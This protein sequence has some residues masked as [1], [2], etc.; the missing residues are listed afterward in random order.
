MTSTAVSTPENTRPARGQAAREATERTFRPEIQGLRA[1]AVLMVVTY[2][3]WFGRVSGGV[4]AFL[5]I[6]AFLMT[7][8]FTRR[9]E[10]GR[11]V[12]LP[13]HYLHVFRR[14]LPAAVLVI[15]SVLIAVRFLIPATRW[16][17]IIGQGLAS[18]FYAQNWALQA[19][20]VDYYASDHSLASPFQHFWSLSIQGQVFILWPLIFVLCA[21]LAR[22]TGW[23]H[24]WILTAVFSAI[25]LASFLHSVEYTA[26][27]Q[28]L[29]YFDTFSRLWEFALGSLLALLLPYLQPSK[30]LRVILG[31]AGVAAMLS[32]G[33][34]LD[35]QGLFPGYVA[36]W[37][38]LAVS[39]V[40]VAGDTGSR[41]GVDRILSSVA[42]TR[43][44]DNSYALYLWH[45]PVL[46]LTLAVADQDSAG[47][48]LGLGV[49]LFS[50]GLAILTTRYVEKPLRSW[51]WV[52]NRTRNT[53]AAT[54]ALVLCAAVPLT[55]WR[56]DYNA[57][58]LT[59]VS[60]SSVT[61]PGAAS[62]DPGYIPSP[63]VT[64]TATVVPRP[65]RV[66]SDWATLGGS[67][68]GEFRPAVGDETIRNC[69]FQAPEGT[70]TK[71]VL[72]VG[73][74]HAQQMLAA[75]KPLAAAKNWNLVAEVKGG[76][77][78]SPEESSGN[79]ECDEF[80]QGVKAYIAQIKPDLVI[81]M[82]TQSTPDSADEQVSTGFTGAAEDLAKQGIQLLGIRDN[83]RSTK[84]VAD[85]ALVK[86]SNNPKCLLARSQ[87]LPA[88]PA[89]ASLEGK[90]TNTSF[91]DLS[92]YICLPDSCPPV[93][94]N[95]RVFL[96]SNHMTQSFVET[97]AGPFATE[98][99]R[100]YTW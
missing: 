69:G 31:W 26:S 88:V 20:S 42:L 10:N 53:V 71:T 24:R 43:L 82:A 29:A 38:T 6:S 89:Y 60:V 19:Q 18:V 25:F 1:M 77:P 78:Y 55:A 70:P 61:N 75:I 45:W 44:G 87:V 47:F 92:N 40:I 7:L 65:E 74:S 66:G 64:A 9:F 63:A 67:C 34:V 33:F 5:L 93:V 95:V 98:F 83:P 56:A 12:N 76:C 27:H 35:V 41:W 100:L 81:T 22:K 91:M 2:H 94:G 21:L 23:N 17:E 80:N 97:L 72:V 62:L 16:A 52:E 32:C 3:V 96:D 57:K 14:L 54:V 13:K 28:T 50:V 46:T 15:V 48:L 51:A 8:Q 99:S 86:G 68:E 4:D 84:N 36:L 73:H 85:C 49:I 58:A 11:Q 59:P 37:P 39:A 30:R 79:E 90:F